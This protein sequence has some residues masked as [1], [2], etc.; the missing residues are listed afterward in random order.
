MAHDVYFAAEHRKRDAAFKAWEQ[1]GN[2]HMRWGNVL[3]A[4]GVGDR[5]WSWA[6][7]NSL[8]TGT[9]GIEQGIYTPEKVYVDM[10]DDLV[11]KMKL[12]PADLRIIRAILKTVKEMKGDEIHD[13]DV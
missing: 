3:M 6:A 9:T 8:S 12:T 11:A 4:M 1:G 5:P 10:E 13:E 7:V 2:Y